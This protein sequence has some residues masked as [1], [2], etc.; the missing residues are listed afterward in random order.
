[1]TPIVSFSTNTTT[2][3]ESV[4]S[5]LTFNFT[6]EGDIPE[7]GLP[8]SLKVDANLDDGNQW[9]FDFDAGRPSINNPNE[10]DVTLTPFARNAEGI[11]GRVFRDITILP[12]VEPPNNI[13]NLVITG[14]EASFDLP[15]FDDE[16]AERGETVVF[17]LLDG[18]GYT[19]NAATTPAAISLLDGPDGVIDATTPVVSLS[20]DQTTV[21][22]GE[23][24]TVNFNV[25]GEI[26][27]GGLTVYVDGDFP[28][29]FQNTFNTKRFQDPI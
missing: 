10:G 26:P 14:N 6:V 9:F 22:E 12:S 5:V 3:V 11:G 28:D 2:L 25:E 23:L 13:I 15:I 29:Y 19:V 21:T 18:E 1:M 24:F 4:G 20:V 7:G 8:I 27:E 17:T 16:F